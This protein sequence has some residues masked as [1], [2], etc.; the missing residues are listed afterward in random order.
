MFAI[1]FD[2]TEAVTEA[3]AEA[4]GGAEQNVSTCEYC[5]VNFRMKNNILHV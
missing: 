5:R 1:N 4:A 3:S 2:M